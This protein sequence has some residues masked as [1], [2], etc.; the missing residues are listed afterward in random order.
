MINKELKRLILSGIP[1]RT[2][3]FQSAVNNADQV[4]ETKFSADSS[5]P[6]RRVLMFKTPIGLICIQKTAQSKINKVFVVETP[7]IIA[8]YFVDELSP[9]EFQEVQDAYFALPKII[10]PAPL[11]EIKLTRT[12]KPKSVE[13]TN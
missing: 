8:S 7:N 1:V 12:R 11:P 10:E 5:V 3:N 2:A 9:E 6:S 13:E 4:P